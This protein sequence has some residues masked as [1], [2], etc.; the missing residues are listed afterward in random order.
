[1]QREQLRR[2]RFSAAPA[3]LCC[4]CSIKVQKLSRHNAEEAEALGIVLTGKQVDAVEAMNDSF[5]KIGATLGGIVAQVTSHLAP[6]IEKISN[7][8]LEMVKQIG[9]ENITTTIT[10]ALFSFADSFLSGLKVLVEVLGQIADGVLALLKKSWRCRKK[11]GR[12]RTC[13]GSRA[14]NQKKNAAWRPVWRC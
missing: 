1:M 8:V 10:E 9:V 3:Y 14:S 2:I 6:T 4:R 12:R 5:T 11:C 7:Q 13:G